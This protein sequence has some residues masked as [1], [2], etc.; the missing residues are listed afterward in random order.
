MSEK[1]GSSSDNGSGGDKQAVV[2]GGGER[3][4]APFIAS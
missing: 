2:K 4:E 3:L 1:E